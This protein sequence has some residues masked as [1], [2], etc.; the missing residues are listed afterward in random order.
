M[1]AICGIASFANDV[2]TTTVLHGM[3]Q[4]LAVHGCDGSGLWQQGA[5]GFAQQGLRV[6]P[7]AMQEQLPWHDPAADLTITADARLDNRAELFQSL[8]IGQKEARDMPDSQL[9]LRGYE[10]WGERCPDYLLGDFAFAIWDG[11]RQSLFCCRDHM[12]VR[13]FFYAY[14]GQRFLFGS[15]AKAILAVPG[16]ARQLNRTRLAAQ[17]ITGARF[18]IPQATFYAD[19]YALPSATSLLVNQQGL[20]KRTYWAPAVRE[21]LPYQRDEEILEALQALLFQ[22]VETRLRSVFPVG[23]LLSGGLDSSALVSV[24]A[25]SLARRGQSLHTFSAVLPD[26][27]DPALNDERDYI[28]QFCPWPNLAMHYVT[29]PQQGPLDGLE[30]LVASYESPVIS[31]RHYLYSALAQAAHSSGVRVLLDGVYGELGPSSHGDGYYAELLRRGCWPTLWRELKARSQVTGATMGVLLRT[32]VLPC[33]MPAAWS[34]G[35]KFRRAVSA[36]IN[37]QVLQP[38]FV[39]EY[40]NKYGAEWRA[41]HNSMN[42]VWP[43][44]RRNQLAQIT[45]V[46]QKYARSDGLVGVTGVEMRY[47]FLDKRLLEFCLAV[48]GELKVHN[49]Y[50]RMLLRSGLAGILPQAIQWRTSKVPFSPDYH[51][52]YNAQRTQAQAF[53]AAIPAT[54]PVTEIVNVTQL[55]QLAAQ[56]MTHARDNTPANHAAMHVVPQGI[57]TIAFL[58]QFAEFRTTDGL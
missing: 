41:M 26:G 19:I 21:E 48:P 23:A 36:S 22:A 6:T 5:V 20:Q 25:Q 18:C 47:P 28:D 46:Y 43:D 15:E 33:F 2:V 14:N 37:Q 17:A 50:T 7:E 9:I 29:D 54:D 44:Q 11:R 56:P 38:A 32:Q 31:S 8:G 1:S 52:R 40:V 34:A 55:R 35:A 57:Y 58:R 53:L 16:V 42:Q 45:A 3:L 30:A 49:G 39:Q 13:P 12:G 24:A 4:T 27:H 51:L 10:R